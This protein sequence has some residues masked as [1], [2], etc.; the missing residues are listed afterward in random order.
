M[1]EK[2]NLTLDEDLEQ[3]VNVIQ[4]LLKEKMSDFSNCITYT[5]K[6]NSI[7]VTKKNIDNEENEFK[8]KQGVSLTFNE[9][10]LESFENELDNFIKENS[11]YDNLFKLPFYDKGK[12]S[13][14]FCGF[15]LVKKV[16]LFFI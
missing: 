11:H 7:D 10:F 4:P 13:S 16:K 6:Y 5:S 12:E 2:D 14:R 3:I 9:D 8:E 1:I 15:C